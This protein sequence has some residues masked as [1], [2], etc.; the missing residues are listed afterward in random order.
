MNRIMNKIGNSSILFS[1]MAILAGLLVGGII[2]AITGQNPVEGILGLLK[3]GYLTSYAIASTLTRATPI[4]FAG[5]SAALAWGSGYSSMG[6]QGQMIIGAITAAIVAP[7]LGFLPPFLAVIITLILSMIAGALYSLISAH[8]SAKYDAY[9]LIVTL[10]LNYLADYLASYLTNYV[11]LDPVALD[12]LAIQ[13]VKI[14]GSI[15]PRIFPRYTMHYGFVIAL[16]AVALTAFII[17]KTSFGY[18]ARMGGLN[19]GFAEY[20]GIDSRKTMYMVLL[21]SGALAGLGGACE[22]LGTKFRYVDKMITSPGY[23]WSGITASLM[24][25]YNIVGVLFSSIFL[26]GIAIGGSTIELSMNIPSEITQIIQGVITMLVTAK[27]V[28]RWHR[29]E[30]GRKEAETK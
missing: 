20:G 25:N 5:L 14:E 22:V 8:I 19:A 21:L 24:S 26:S 28:I 13:T 27:F 1:L 16:I 11:F 23:S 17:N 9:L 4:I 10:M 7:R 3:G 18:K 2:M 12:K 15:L 6:A 30:N 29:K